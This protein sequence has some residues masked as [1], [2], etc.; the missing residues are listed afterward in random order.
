MILLSFRF[1]FRNII[2]NLSVQDLAEQQRL[3]WHSPDDDVKMCIVKGKDEV[4]LSSI[5]C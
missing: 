2:Y 3:I 4:W 5:Y 1:L